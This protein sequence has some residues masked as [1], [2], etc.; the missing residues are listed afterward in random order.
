MKECL[1]ILA[2]YDRPNMVRQALHSVANQ[3]EDNWHL[4][5]I[6]DASKTPGEPIVREI[7]G[8][9]VSKCTFYRINDSEELKKK[10]G[11]R[12]PEFMN[13]AVLEAGNTDTENP[14]IILCDDDALL[15]DY[16]KK[17]SEYYESQPTVMY[18][19]CHVIPYNPFTE[20]YTDLTPRPFGY[21]YSH[22]L[23][24][25]STVD[26][27]QVTYRRAAFIRDG[28]R[29]PSPAYRCLDAALY[30]RLRPYGLCPFNGILGQ[31]KGWNYGDQLG[32]RNHGNELQP[33]DLPTP[34][35]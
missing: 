14:V 13:K 8:D 4:A 33:R 18:S 12:H 7:L 16:T 19:Y 28:V 21:N 22:P 9:K 25:F 11:S 17:L 5:F 23:W 29:Y 27:S 6:D 24:P 20:K 15:P 1:I 26:S 34:L 35:L 3:I 30:D 31:A 32:A 2:Y 10:Q